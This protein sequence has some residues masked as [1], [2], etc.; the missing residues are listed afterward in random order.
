MSWWVCESTAP[1]HSWLF[2]WL[3][4]LIQSHAGPSST[5]KTTCWR[6]SLPYCAVSNKRPQPMTFS[7]ETKNANQLYLY[8]DCV[9]EMRVIYTVYV[10]SG[11][12]ISDGF[13]KRTTPKWL[14]SNETLSSSS[15]KAISYV[16]RFALYFSWRLISEAVTCVTKSLNK[17]RSQQY[18]SIWNSSSSIISK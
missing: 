4:D 5:T 15:S 9:Y 8:W 13:G 6:I 10:P 18:K 1:A 7:F 16:W 3:L 12:Y 14:S 17:Q 2:N 11:G